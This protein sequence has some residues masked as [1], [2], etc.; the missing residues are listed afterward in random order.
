[1]FG[2]FFVLLSLLLL[3]LFFFRLVICIIHLFIYI[4]SRHSNL[5]IGTSKNKYIFFFLFYCLSC[6]LKQLT[7]VRIIMFFVLFLFFSRACLLAIWFGVA[8]ERLEKVLCAAR[9][10]NAK[11]WREKKKNKNHSKK[12]DFWFYC[13]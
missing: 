5:F 2:L 3:L 11:G 13:Y 9:E 1:M 12:R 8:W 10:C 7:Y 6:L 4:F